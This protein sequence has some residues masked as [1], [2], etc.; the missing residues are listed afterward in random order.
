MTPLSSPF[1]DWIKLNLWALI[2]QNS[3]FSTFIAE[4]SFRMAIF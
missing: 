4:N 2:H 3:N 1:K